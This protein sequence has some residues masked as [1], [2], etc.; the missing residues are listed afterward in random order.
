MAT[1]LPLTLATLPALAAG[2][3]V[4]SRVVEASSG[5]TCVGATVKTFIP[6]DSIATAS[7]A[8][9]DPDGKFT[10]ELENPGDYMAEISY[11]GCRDIR[12]PFTVSEEN[13]DIVLDDITM[14]Q[15]DKLLEEVLVVAR[16]KLIKSDG[17]TLTY[18]VEEDPTSKTS[19]TLEMLRHVPMVSVDAEDNVRVN[20]QTNYKIYINGKEDPML[21]GDVKTVLK[22]MPA[23]T[24]KRIEVITEPGAKYDAAGSGAILNIVT[25][26]QTRV[27]GYLA[28]L[29]LQG[30]NY[31]GGGA[32]YAMTKI[33]KVTASLSGNCFHSLFDRDI[34][35]T[36]TQEM[37]LSQRERI[38]IANSSQNND[39]LFA[40]GNFNLSW[41]PDTLNLYTVAFSIGNYNMETR[42][43]QDYNTM[44]AQGD[45]SWRYY[46]HSAISDNNMWM[47][48]T[49]S[50]QHT[51]GRQGHH[52]IFSYIYDH[53]KDK[54]SSVTETYDYVGLAIPYPWRNSLRD[55]VSDKHSLQIDYANPLTANH[56]IEAGFK[57]SWRPDN[58]VNDQGYGLT[59]DDITVDPDERIDLKQFQDIMAAYLSY[60]GTFGNFN[61]RVGL[62]YE[63][64]RMG[65]RYRIGDYEDFTT[66][67]NDLVPNA[68]LTYKF[69]PVS[70]LRL[71]YQM[72]INRPGLSMLNPY[73]NTMTIGEVSYG[74]PGLDSEHSHNITL[75]YSNYGGAV[76][77]SLSAGY[78]NNSNSIQSY[79]FVEDDVRHTTYANIGHNN[80][81]MLN[82]NMQW[83]PMSSL[84]F[85]VSG[86]LYYTDI[87]VDTPLLKD[88]T[89]G[90]SANINASADYTLPFGLRVSAYY[91]GG[92]R[93]IAL[94]NVGGSGWYYYGL[95]LSRDFLKE[96]RLS[97]NVSAMNFINPR[98]EYRQ[99]TATDD[100]R[101][102]SCMSYPAW[103]VGIGISYRLGSLSARVRNTDARIETE[104]GSAGGMQ[105]GGMPR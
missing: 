6:S 39:F 29:T 53:G 46:R 102:S 26:T 40:N 20:G 68:S 50:Y 23:A 48:A 77:G 28:N 84:Q 38:Q 8:V 83:T 19:S 93:D 67:L 99:E 75:A 24:I 58:C 79:M 95:G 91:G 92:T 100:L 42:V 103:N 22:S 87:R 74:N 11:I 89:S 71:A 78:M 73:R 52:L 62:R 60:T 81:F 2:Y 59:G 54:R 5:E 80:M 61:T 9:T 33:D 14:T 36:T 49:A 10:R 4:S 82:G 34:H 7:F 43:D 94:Q 45:L 70:N 31:G 27:E 51:F 17:A 64:T 86:G 105:G 76:G 13:P 37:P 88:H 57:G 85:S 15:D 101:I 32:L 35:G 104:G 21:N 55:G 47:S 63:H 69:T 25:A 98:R 56:L 3:S 12:I 44:D 90:W 66:Y 16:R 30:S 1:V 72:R 96:K 65:M 18:S 41:E 97:V